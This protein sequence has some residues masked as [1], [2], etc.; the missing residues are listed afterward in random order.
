MS[1]PTTHSLPLLQNVQIASP[2]HARW[3]EMSGDERTRRCAECNL[4]VHNLSAMTQQEAEA[5]LRPY[6]D[7]SGSPQGR[8]CA[9]IYRRSDGTVLTADCPVGAAA[10]RDKARRAAARVVAALGITSL[11][12]AAAAVEQRH[13]ST[14]RGCQPFSALAS[15]MGRHPAMQTQTILMGSVA[16]MPP[17][18]PAAG[19]G[20]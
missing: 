10:V 15:A 3:E 2:C 9:R 4:S 20:R 17:A 1:T 8:I 14:L 13:S 6:F 7:D 19:D 12:T 5:L 11:I 16:P 18:P